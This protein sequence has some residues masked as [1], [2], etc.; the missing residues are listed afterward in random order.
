MMVYLK[1]TRKIL[2]FNSLA[3]TDNSVDIKR[4]V[5]CLIVSYSLD[6]V[7]RIQ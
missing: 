1:T 4:A 3:I 6:E 5:V 2:I 7:L